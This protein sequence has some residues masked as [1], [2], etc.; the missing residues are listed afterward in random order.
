M[1]ACIEIVYNKPDSGYYGDAGGEKAVCG[2][3]G[4]NHAP[5]SPVWTQYAG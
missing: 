4:M 3:L 2:V 5:L 1:F